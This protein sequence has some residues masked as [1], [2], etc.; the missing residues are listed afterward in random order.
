MAG[1][2]QIITWILCFYLV[3]KGVE[4]LQISLA[5]SRENRASM[6][7]WAVVVLAICIVAA[8]GFIAMQDQQ[9]S[10][11]SQNFRNQ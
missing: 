2:L 3:L 11:L 1:M 7:I 5:S 10:S 9:A 6:I 4:I 8:G